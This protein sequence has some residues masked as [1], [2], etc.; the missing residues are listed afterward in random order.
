LLITRQGSSKTNIS[1]V[2]NTEDAE[3]CVKAIHAD[4]F[5]E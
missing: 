4:F 3:K 2:V 5:S 1:F